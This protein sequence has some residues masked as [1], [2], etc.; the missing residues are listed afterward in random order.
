VPGGDGGGPGGRIFLQ[1]GPGVAYNQDSPFT[2]TSS[3]AR[4]HREEVAARLGR[5]LPTVEREPALIRSTCGK[6]SK[7]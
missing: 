3:R 7:P 2:G 6:E 5:S 4:G 1:T